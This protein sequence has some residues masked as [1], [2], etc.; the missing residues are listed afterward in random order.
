[1]R[2][3]NVVVRSISSQ[4]WQ[5][6]SM[7]EV[8]F[9]HFIGSQQRDCIL[10]SCHSCLHCAVHLHPTYLPSISSS[11][12]ILKTWKATTQLISATVPHLGPQFNTQNGRGTADGVERT[13][14]EETAR[15]VGNGYFI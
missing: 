7:R 1:M 9:T 12:G 5:N 14:K 4:G 13:T 15:H 3:R 11:T 8:E 6:N 2:L 10:V